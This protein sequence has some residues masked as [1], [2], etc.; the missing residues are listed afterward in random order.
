MQRAAEALRRSKR[1][2]FF[3]GAGISAD[4]GIPTFRDKLTGLWEKHDPQRLETAD[5]FRENPALVW[6]WYLWR[7][8]QVSS[9]E[10]NSAHLSISK[11]A[12]AGWEVSVITQNIDDLH[13]RAGFQDVVHL[14]GSLMGVKCFACHRPV[15]LNPEQVEISEEGQLVEPPR[16]ARCNGRLRPGIVWFK[17]NLPDDAWRSAVQLVRRCDLLISV[18]TS[19]VV[20]PAASIPDMALA[21][22]ASVI[23]VNLEDVGLEGANEIMVIGRAEVVLPALLRMV[24]ID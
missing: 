21:A 3:T 4:S 14:H 17:E 1:V 2:V 19:G 23:H 22:G 9:A 15:E 6:G 11:L 10:P 20:M 5:A 7:R 12:H 18:G 13:E 24:G 16:C 8:L